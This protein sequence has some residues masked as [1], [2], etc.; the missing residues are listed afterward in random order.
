MFGVFLLNRISLILNFLTLL[1]LY[2]IHVFVEGMEK[3][4]SS[5]FAKNNNTPKT[6]STGIQN[7]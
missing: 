1:R 7:H 2:S 3:N 5:I 4:N 6:E